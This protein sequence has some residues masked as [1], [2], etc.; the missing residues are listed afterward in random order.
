MMLKVGKWIL[1][2][3]VLGVLALPTYA[4]VGIF[5]GNE[6]IGAVGAAGS[7]KYSETDKEYQIEGSGADIWDVAD[8]FHYVYKEISGSFSIKGNVYALVG[9]GDSTW[10]KCGFMVRDNLTAGSPHAFAMIRGG[11]QDFGPQYRSTQDAS[12]GDYGTYIGGAEN[13]TMVQEGDIELERLGSTVNCY[14]TDMVTTERVKLCSF[15]IPALQ[16]PVYVGMAV[17]SHNDGQ[18]STGYFKNVELTE[19]A[20]DASLNVPV[21]AYS[22]SQ[23]IEGISLNINVKQG[24]T[25]KKLTVTGTVPAGLTIS[26]VKPSAGTPSLV[27]DQLKWELTDLTGS[28]SL[29]FDL[30]APTRKDYGV[31]NFTGQATDGTLVVPISASIP[32]LSFNTYETFSYPGEKAGTAL[33]SLT[34]QRG[35]NW[36]SA[37]AN[38]GTASPNALDEK[39]IEAGLVQNQPQEYNPGGFCLKVT[40]A[41]DN[42]VGRKFQTVSSGELWASFV[43]LDEGPAAS[44]WAGMTF[45]SSGGAESSFIGKPYNAEKAGIGNLSGDDSLT[46]ADYKVANHYLV[47]IVL[48]PGAGQNDSV[49]LWINPD[50]SDRMDT[51]DAGG[52]NND[53]IDNISEIRLR[54]GGASGSSYFDDIWISSDPALPPAGAGRVDLTF[55]NPNRDPNLPVWDV[56]SIDQ[57]D[58]GIT[59]EAGFGHDNG[60]NYYLIVAGYLYYNSSG[61]AYVANGLPPDRMSGLNGHVFGPYN[62]AHLELGLKNSMKFMNNNA[63]RGPFTFNLVPKG[64]YSEL[65]SAMTVGNGYGVLKCTL[66]YEDGSSELTEIHADDWFRDPTD[67]D[68]MF[69]DVILLIDGMDRLEGDASTFADSNDPAVN[70]DAT[71]V[72]PDKVLVS[73]TLELDPAKSGNGGNVGYNLYDIWAMPAGSETGV[74][75][76]SLF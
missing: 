72:N 65:R 52:A 46:T 44:H 5:T 38:S 29:V 20:F 24:Q 66:N 74:N 68:W 11:G 37:W 56:I 12:S 70:E 36:A 64:K 75:D 34:T 15:N 14:Y 67:S 7:A 6:D 19:Y 10:T 59:G 73:V 4:Q 41:A 9:G 31:I 45:Y 60:N 17:T 30:A 40:G 27:G 23:T 62:D 42:G 71:A 32:M 3:C 49:Y 35:Y 54:R 63:Q 43:F 76:W 69:K 47:R 18:L 13:S 57:Y 53:S 25:I 48:N 51:Y 33:A 55:N 28:A 8:E 1:G 26:N 58:D 22:V 39:V 16:D 21:A 61:T 50:E 2:L